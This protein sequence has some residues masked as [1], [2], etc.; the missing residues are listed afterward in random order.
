MLIEA[1]S[2]CLEL[3]CQ[4]GDVLAVSSVFRRWK[5]VTGVNGPDDELLDELPVE[6][7]Q[8][9]HHE[10]VHYLLSHGATMKPS[11]P[12]LVV[13]NVAKNIDLREVF[14]VFIE[15][16]GWAINE[17]SGNYKPALRY[18]VN[19]PELVTSFLKWG[20][21]PN[22]V[23]YDGLTPLDAAAG[24]ATTRIVD[25]LLAAGATIKDAY[26]LHQAVA[27]SSSEAMSMIKHLL[28]LG[29]DIDAR[30]FEHHPKR[31][32]LRPAEKDFGT[33]LHYAIRSGAEQRVILL[34]ENGADATKR[35]SKRRSPLCWAERARRPKVHPETLR[36]LS[37]VEKSV[38]DGVSVDEN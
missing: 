27:T 16:G 12:G 38:T 5:E 22:A 21:D 18:V 34:F 31:A 6:A 35:S 3:S 32:R 9:G 24:R 15:V 2:S 33:P 8:N 13:V 29:V 30:L 36:L 4:T 7:A 1:L 14:R 25:Q 17:A 20:A 19:R 37:E 11:V 26:P 10:T 23:G 28:A